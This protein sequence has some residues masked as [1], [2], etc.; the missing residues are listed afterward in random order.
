MIPRAY[1]TEWQA[2][3]PWQANEQI[4]QDLIICRSIAELFSDPVLQANLAFR[5]GTALYKLHLPKVRYSEDIDLVQTEPG[6]MKP[7]FDA[8]HE[9]MSF[10]GTP[11]VRQKYRNNTL[12][13]QF[14]SEIPPQVTMRLKIENCCRE[15]ISAF[16]LIKVPFQVESRWYTGTS[17]IT[18][19]LLEE[20]LGSKLRALYQRKKG[21]DLFDMWYA[22]ENAKV[23]PTKIL[24]AFKMYM[25]HVDSKVTQKQFIQNM[26]AK[27]TD[28][29][30]SGDITGLL[31]TDV[32]FDIDEAWKKVK[33]EI[34]DNL[35]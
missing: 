3:A 25:E 15:H 11:R 14:E 13:Y 24:G 28:N 9:R 5:G 32:K 33:E 2:Q 7:I 22:L 18:T 17:E 34:V 26:E 12:Y 35:K 1:I 30:F 8:L 16:N 31:K 4:E 23:N 29:D 6:P 21:R 27:I 19:Y 10:M 20:L